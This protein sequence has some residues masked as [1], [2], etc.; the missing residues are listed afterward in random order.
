MKNENHWHVPGKTDVQKQHIAAHDI[1]QM[2]QRHAVDKEW[3]KF[4]TL[5]LDLQSDKHDDIK[6]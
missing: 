2:L 3:E 1:I 6:E 5:L 4:D